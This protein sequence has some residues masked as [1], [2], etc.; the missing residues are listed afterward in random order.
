MTS[1]PPRTDHDDCWLCGQDFGH[2]QCGGSDLRRGTERRLSQTFLPNYGVF[3]EYRYFKAG[4]AAPIFVYGQVPI[5]VNIC[6][7]IWYPGGP[8]KVQALA[9]AEVIINISAS[10]YYAGKGRDRERMLGD[11][12]GR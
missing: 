1:S 3:D 8:M 7:D 12:R 2:S 10:P 4:E 6:E 9:G 11:A 5:G